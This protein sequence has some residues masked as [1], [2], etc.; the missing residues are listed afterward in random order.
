MSRRLLEVADLAVR[1]DGQERDAVTGVSFDLDAGRCVAFVGET[2]S[3]KTSSVMAAVRLLDGAEIR[4][5]RLRMEGRDLLSA[6]AGQIR[7]LRR[8][9][10]GVV[11]QDPAASWNPTRRVSAQLMET[12]P[13]AQRAEA[14]GRLVGLCERVGIVKSAE[15]IDAYPHQL[16]GGQLQRFMIAGALLHDPAV[17]VADEPTSALDASVQLELIEL[18]DELRRERQLGL[19]LV[20]H[21]LGVVA[22]LAD[23]VVVMFRGEVVERGPVAQVVHAP[24][25]PYTRSLLAASLDMTTPR[26]V[27]L[28]TDIAWDPEAVAEEEVA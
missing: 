1:Y 6:D 23:T 8:R 12:T 17:M 18:L 25:H 4:A 9:S 11:F 19:L 3:G 21:D 26:K 28:A 14:R 24:T 10:L 20:S 16:S 15:R 5:E 7:A 22:R 27:P 2:G 13:R